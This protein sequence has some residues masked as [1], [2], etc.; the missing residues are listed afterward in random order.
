MYRTG[1]VWSHRTKTGRIVYEKDK[2]SFTLKDLFRITRK[3]GEG[4]FT[5]GRGGVENL[6]VDIY[7]LITERGGIWHIPDRF[8]VILKPHTAE[9]TE[10][11]IDRFEEWEWDPTD[12]LDKPSI[13]VIIPE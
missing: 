7:N 8:R 2:K 5:V 13:I 4:Y 10:E 12:W 6:F 3:V 1:A 11:T 9:A